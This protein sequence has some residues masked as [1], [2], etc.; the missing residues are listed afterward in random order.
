MRE[1]TGMRAYKTV[2]P[3]TR[4]W[5]PSCTS[6]CS[7]AGFVGGRHHSGTG[8]R[9]LSCALGVVE[10]RRNEL[11]ELFQTPLGIRRRQTIVGRDAEQNLTTAGMDV[12][13]RPDHGFTMRLVFDAILLARTLIPRVLQAPQLPPSLRKWLSRVS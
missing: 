11:G 7:R 12:T 13:Y 4:C 6:R 5:A 1:S 8:R 9:K 2:P 3:P 10:R